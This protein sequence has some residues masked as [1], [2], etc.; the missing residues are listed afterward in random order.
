MAIHAVEVELEVVVDVHARV[1][2]SVLVDLG[3]KP[4]AL[5]LVRADVEES[6]STASLTLVMRD[7][8]SVIAEVMAGSILTRVTGRVGLAFIC[9]NPLLLE[10]LIN[11]KGSRAFA[12]SYLFATVPTGY[13]I[14]R[15]KY[16]I[17]L[18]V[19]Y[20]REPVRERL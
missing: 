17:R 6:R 2:W 19:S 7:R 20:Y 3:L 1:D 12:T 10:V 16:N 9:R 13:H 5:L 8:R 11:V 18:V 4:F 15:R 14:L